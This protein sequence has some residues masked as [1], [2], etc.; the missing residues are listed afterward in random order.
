[1]I[2]A[3]FILGIFLSLFLSEVI[4]LGLIIRRAIALTMHKL[5]EHDF[6]QNWL[7]LTIK[8]MRNTYNVEHGYA[9]HLNLETNF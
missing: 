4:L 2:R 5:F 3:R 9:I 1:M 6:W 7:K 8:R